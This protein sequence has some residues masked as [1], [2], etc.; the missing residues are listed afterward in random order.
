[1]GQPLSLLSRALAGETLDGLGDAGGQGALP[2]VEQP[3][4]RNFVSERVL[5]RVLEVREEP[6]LVEELRSLEV[7]QLGAYLGL[8]RVGDGQEQR[9]RHVFA[10]DRASLEQPLGLGPQP[11]DTCGQD[12]L[13]SGGDRQL[14]DG[15]GE[16]VAAALA[17]QGSYLHQRSVWQRGHFIGTPRHGAPES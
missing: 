5:E 2:L 16:P 6:G 13:H 11:V 7:G 8:G 1:V 14:L 10:D 12:G 4:V 15:P 3:L 17:D 9:H